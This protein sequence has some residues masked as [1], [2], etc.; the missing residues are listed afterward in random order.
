MQYTISAQIY[1]ISGAFLVKMRH[2][3]WNST[4]QHLD[5]WYGAPYE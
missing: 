1:H 4:E 3:S 2:F 5:Y